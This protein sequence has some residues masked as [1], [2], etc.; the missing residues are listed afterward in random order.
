MTPPITYDTALAELS[1]AL[2]FG[3][4]PSLDGITALCAALGNPQNAFASVQ[5][6][7]TNG[8]SSTARITAALLRAEGIATGLYTS[9]ELERYPERIEIG[10]K[11]VSDDDF[12][13]ALG[14][15]LAAARALRGDDAV[16][17]ATGFT[18]FE[19]LTAAALWIFRERC[20]SVAVLEVGMGGRWD[21]TSVVSPSVAAITGVGLDHTAILGDTLEAI[22]AEKAAI[23]RPSTVPVLG[24]GTVGV[25]QVFLERTAALGIPARAVRAEGEPAPVAEALTVRHTLTARPS[26][27]GGTTV[28]DVR[29]IHAAYCALAVA[30]P[31][32]QSANVATAVAIAEAA[33][34]HA[35][36][37][38]AAREALS[39]L[40]F[41]GRFELVRAAPPVIVDGSHNPQAAAVLATAVRDA[42]PA[43]PPTLLL[44]ILADK[45]ARGI[46]AAL[47]FAVDRIA[48]TQ[49]DSPRALPVAKLAAIVDEITG[50]S[51]AAAYSSIAQALVGELPQSP[52][53]LLVTGSLTTAGQARRL[54]REMR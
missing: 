23:I 38:A 11:V 4:N 42:F 27:P 31:S 49:S 50:A 10:G 36:D 21:A 2:A 43:E 24:P 25:E 15:A 46:V 13:L 7:G 41:P 19:L 3:I 9:P 29:G 6:T 1:R 53:G 14:A 51:K 44:A 18:E 22:A 48:V 17:T 52:A 47:A 26:S 5:I 30:A 12:A 35:L 37:A 28:V 34:G 16:G 8:K 39:A 40:T 32:Y 45:D 54:L 20:V 33:L